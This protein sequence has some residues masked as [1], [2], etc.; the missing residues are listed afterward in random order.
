MADDRDPVWQEPNSSFILAIDF[1]RC[2]F[3]QKSSSKDNNK[4]GKERCNEKAEMGGEDI[5]QR[6]A[7]GV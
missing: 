6:G 1:L 4:R 3:A 5:G 7:V 2:T